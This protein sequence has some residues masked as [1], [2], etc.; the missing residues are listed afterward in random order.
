MQE[1]NVEAIK[2]RF[3]KLGRDQGVMVKPNTVVPLNV[4]EETF[5]DNLPDLKRVKVDAVIVTGKCLEKLNSDRELKEAF[6]DLCEGAKVVLA[7]RVAPKQ[8]ADIVNW[9]KIRNPNKNTLAIGD[10]ANDVNMITAAHIGVGILGR[11]GA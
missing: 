8:K 1:D 5:T 11:E 9:V 10:G 4:T 3:H 2:G 7:C 6:I